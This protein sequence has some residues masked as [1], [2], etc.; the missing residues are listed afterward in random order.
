[1]GYV[2]GFGPGDKVGRGRHFKIEGS[3]FAEGLGFGDV[4]V[5]CDATTSKPILTDRMPC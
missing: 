1:M 3:V 5:R 4:V 2:F